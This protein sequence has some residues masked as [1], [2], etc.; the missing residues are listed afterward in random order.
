MIYK[1]VVYREGVLESLL[2][3]GANINPDKFT[4]FLNQYAVQGWRVVTMEKDIQR[5]FLFWKREAYVLEMGKA[6]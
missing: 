6:A 3:G 4:T 2:P 5:L 1:V